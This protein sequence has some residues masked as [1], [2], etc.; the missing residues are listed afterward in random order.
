MPA[1]ISSKG[2]FHKRAAFF[3]S[4]SKKCGL[5]GPGGRF[6]VVETYSRMN[7]FVI[8]W[9]GDNI[10]RLVIEDCID[11]DRISNEEKFTHANKLPFG[12]NE[13]GDDEGGA[14]HAFV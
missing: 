12:A 11:Q 13:A 6:A 14:H 2:V 8:E 5:A 9:V 1:S 7:G 4:P 3:R 10:H